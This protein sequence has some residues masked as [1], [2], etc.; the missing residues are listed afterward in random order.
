MSTQIEFTQ[1][2]NDCRAV[3]RQ[4]FRRVERTFGECD[5]LMDAL[6]ADF[7]RVVGEARLALRDDKVED[8]L[9][10]LRS[11]LQGGYAELRQRRLQHLAQRQRSLA[12]FTVMLFGRT[13]SG[14]STFREAITGGDGSSIGKGGQRTTRDVREYEWKHLTIVD[15][16]GFGAFGGADDTNAAREVLARSDVVIFML[17]SDSIQESTFHEL[18]HVHRL[19]KPLIFALNVKNDLSD[20][21][22]RRR[23]LRDPEKYLYHPDDL[24]AHLKRLRELSERAGL[25]AEHVRIVPIHAQAAFLARQRDGEEG[26]TLR[27]L[28][29][30]DD[31]LL[32]LID[33]V[34]L[35]GPVRRV[36][37]FIDS[38]LFHID[39]QVKLVKGQ[40]DDLRRLSGEYTS[41]ISR[42]ETWRRKL[43]RAR[44]RWI[45][46]EVDRAYRRLID[47]VADFVDDNI[48]RNDFAEQWQAHCKAHDLPARLERS[49]QTMADEV[50]SELSGFTRDLADSIQLAFEQEQVEVAEAFDEWDYKRIGNW[51]SALLGIV[52]TIAFAMSWNPVGW[53]LMGAGALLG[54]ASG[55]A[56]SRLSKLQKAKSTARQRLLE[57]LEGDK[58]A[59]RRRMTTWFDKRLLSD[60]V[61]ATQSRLERLAASID[62]FGLALR[63]AEQRFD[64]TQ[65]DL[66]GRL[67]QRVATI[68]SGRQG[69]LPH[70]RRIA[71]APGYATYL[72]AAGAPG[73]LR[74]LGDIQ[75][76]LK[77]RIQLVRLGPLDA[78]LAHLFGR[79]VQRV[80]LVG[81]DEAILHAR[82]N[83]LSRIHGKRG[84]RI[85]LA[86][87]LTSSRLRTSEHKR[88]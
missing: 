13:M 52:S 43:E 48:E 55:F 63:D 56:D 64:D 82:T 65:Q 58:A 40:A 20:D 79:L 73:D 15:T 41:A 47:S 50:T 45:V 75:R 70:V 17:N 14:K 21:G 23:A 81:A 71:R 29:R 19:N 33:E 54:I 6:E 57:H 49:A 25:R 9:L 12:R 28:S 24:A 32:L 80:E 18:Q 67:L 72:L 22:N 36:Q 53:I 2:L 46:A 68:I 61:Q 5:A 86:A 34:R 66:N 62:A 87:T 38:A 7:D 78:M 51:G 10:E 69:A 77:E 85:K 16:P 59:A 1:A 39:D 88:A 44:E 35:H 31:L 60:T 37:G 83:D 84:R 27:R 11:R 26:A 74:L 76:V 3:A 4:E 42:I 8:G 30:L